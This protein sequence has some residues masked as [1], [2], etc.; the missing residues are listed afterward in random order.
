MTAFKWLRTGR[1]TLEP[2]TKEGVLHQCVDWE[3]LAAW[4]AGRRVDLF[5]PRTLVPPPRVGVV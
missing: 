2:S 5:D 3:R 1:H 4:A